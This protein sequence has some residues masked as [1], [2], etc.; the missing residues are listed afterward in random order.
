MADALTDCEVIFY[1]HCAKMSGAEISMLNTV[2]AMHSR[3]TVILGEHGPLE[4]HLRDAGAEVVCI[5]V[6]PDVNEYSRVDV[7]ISF[8]TISR[9]VLALRYARTLGRELRRRHARVVVSNSM[10]SH[11]ILAL[12]RVFGRFEIVFYLHDRIAREFMSGTGVRLERLLVRNVAKAVIANSRSTL[13]TAPFSKRHEMRVV[14]GGPIAPPPSH[15]IR[16]AGLGPRSKPQ[17]PLT[18]GLVGRMTPW[19]GQDVAIRA[20]SMAFPNGSEQLELAGAPLFGE[21]QYVDDLHRL[22]QSLDLT[23][24]VRFLGHVED[25]YAV[26]NEWD[27]ALH[28]S[29]IP[30]PF[31]LV[32]AQAMAIGLPVIASD[33]GGPSEMISSEMTGLLVAPNDPRSLAQALQRLAGDEHLRS[34]LGERAAAAVDPYMPSVAAA[35]VEQAVIAA[36][37]S[38]HPSRAVSPFTRR[39]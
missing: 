3:V 31:G 15:F 37:K 32:V 36:G 7:K 17:R 28:T 9:A 33:E 21:E 1:D 10:K 11:V 22:V 26:M 24:R 18:V 29:V 27:I 8:A 14:T 25:P 30:E 4:Q 6:P 12:A 19:K 35:V 20:F 39:R 34:Q 13:A 23:A 38:R 5:V 2:A 16:S